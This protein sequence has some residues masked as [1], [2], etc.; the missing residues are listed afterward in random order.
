MTHRIDGHT[1]PRGDAVSVYPDYAIEITKLAQV[2]V[3]WTFTK[4]HQL[5]YGVN[6]KFIANT[7]NT[8]TC[9]NFSNPIA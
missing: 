8:S 3:S 1:D 5:T 9:P 7:H 4:N 2:I 6:L